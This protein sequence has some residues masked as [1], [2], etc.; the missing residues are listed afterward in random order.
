VGFLEPYFDQVVTYVVDA[1]VARQGGENGKQ[2]LCHSQ[3][4]FLSR[5][6]GKVF[7]PKVEVGPQTR[8]PHRRLNGIRDFF[9][10]IHVFFII[11][12]YA[13]TIYFL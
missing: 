3:P 11:L 2:S 5:F 10:Q 4:L 7:G 1:Q 9:H 6:H 8:S 12:S 13:Q